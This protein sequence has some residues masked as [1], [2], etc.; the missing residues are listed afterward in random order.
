MITIGINYIGG[1]GHDASAAL[2][3]DGKIEYAIAEERISREKQDGNFP[4]NAIKACLE[5][6]G[7]TMNEVDELVF[8]WP[9][10]KGLF[11]RK[12]KTEPKWHIG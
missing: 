4:I 8:G 1:L 6:K 10:L 9:K 3:V 12:P 5:Y 7:I 2:A 11:F